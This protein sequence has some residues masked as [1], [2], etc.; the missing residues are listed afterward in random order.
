M[1][2]ATNDASSP[3]VTGSYVQNMSASQFEAMFPAYAQ[4]MSAANGVESWSLTH[5]VP[6]ARTLTLLPLPLNEIR[7]HLQLFV[8]DDSMNLPYRST[9]ARTVYVPAGMPVT[10]IHWKAKA[11]G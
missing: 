4:S 5:D 1:A 10:S 2:R 7:A 9:A 8:S 11:A 3:R 6:L